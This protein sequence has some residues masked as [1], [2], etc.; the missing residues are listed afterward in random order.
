MPRHSGLE[1]VCVIM[2]AS[3]SQFGLFGPDPESRSW[4]STLGTGRLGCTGVVTA[5]SSARVGFPGAQ[6]VIPQVDD[7]HGSCI[8]DKLMVPCTVVWL[9]QCKKVED[10]AP[11]GT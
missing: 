11:K 2:S 3:S 8:G 10:G 7:T 4:M 9:E 6:L 1:E 5:W